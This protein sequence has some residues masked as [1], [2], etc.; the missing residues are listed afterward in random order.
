MEAHTV[1]NR[2]LRKEASLLIKKH[3]FPSKLYRGLQG[4]RRY[5]GW[6]L[7]TLIAQLKY[8]PGDLVGDCDGANHFVKEIFWYR[9]SNNRWWGNGQKGYIF[10]LKNHSFQDE[11]YSCG[12]SASPESPYTREEIEKRW[13]DL[14]QDQQDE[15]EIDSRGWKIYCW[16]KAGGHIYD[17]NGIMLPEWRKTYA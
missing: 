3:G 1:G 2:A 10:C 17:E 5:R 6:Q 12:C 11:T 7:R 8:M 15:L 13:I 16:I 9:S 14:T 4:K